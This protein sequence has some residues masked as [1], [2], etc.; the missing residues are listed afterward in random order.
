MTQNIKFK[1]DD[2]MMICMRCRGRKKMY[3][4][5]GGGY[6]LMNSGGVEV[7]C[8]MCLGKGEHK[9]LEAAQD[10]MKKKKSSKNKDLVYGQENGC[11]D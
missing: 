2:T 6:S 3:K 4:I 9:T 1:K 8:P 7:D 11:A 10:E 5:M